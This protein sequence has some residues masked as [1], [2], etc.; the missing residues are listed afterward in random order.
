[1]ENNKEKELIFELG[2]MST[3]E[4]KVKSEYIKIALIPTGSIER[5]GPNMSLET[6]TAIAYGLSEK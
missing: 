2:S 5:H 3:Y 4:L 1:M 6:D